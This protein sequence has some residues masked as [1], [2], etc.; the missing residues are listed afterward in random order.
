MHW[1]AKRGHESKHSSHG[2]KKLLRFLIPGI[3]I[4]PSVLENFEVEKREEK[5]DHALDEGREIGLHERHE[6]YNDPRKSKS[7]AEKA[8]KEEVMGYRN[9]YLHHY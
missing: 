3:K 9:H 2:S 6:A 8:L 1:N 7:K 4:S 5:L